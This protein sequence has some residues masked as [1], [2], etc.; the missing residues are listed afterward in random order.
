M[1]K[2]TGGRV[3]YKGRDLWAMSKDE[4]RDYRREVQAIFQDPFAVFNPFYTIDRLLQTPIRTFKL[5][6]SRA[7]AKLLI[8]DALTKVGL[9]PRE[10]LGR[11]SASAQRRTTAA[12]RGRAQ[13]AATAES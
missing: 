3:I 13:S 9:R 8:D 7:D 2:P 12:H 10:V 11:L 1:I 4:R 5:A 6:K